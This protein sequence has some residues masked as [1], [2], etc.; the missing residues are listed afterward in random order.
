MSAG[1]TTYTMLNITSGLSYGNTYNFFVISYDSEDSTVLPSDHSTTLSLG[2]YLIKLFS[3]ILTL[4]I[5]M[6]GYI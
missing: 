4:A 2:K 3:F 6:W 5:P 1:A